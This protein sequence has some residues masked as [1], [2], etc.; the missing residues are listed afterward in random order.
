MRTLKAIILGIIF[1]SGMMPFAFADVYINVMAVNGAQERKETSVKY[2]LPGDLKE[3]DILDTSGLTLQYNV[4]DANYYVTGSVTLDPKETKTF[5]IRVKD[6]WRITPEQTKQIKD[7][8]DRGFEQVGKLYDAAKGEELK[9]RLEKKLDEITQQQAAANSV[10]QRI[11]AYRSY[12][13]EVARIRDEALAVDYWKSSP[14]QVKADRIIRLKID[15]ENPIDGE[16]KPIKEKQYL[17]T[18]VKP[19]DVV[20]P[21][22]FEIRYDQQRQQAFLFKEEE[23]PQGQKRSYSIGIRDIWHIEQGDMDY[24]RKRAD[25]ANDFLKNSK[26]A[27][28]AKILYDQIDPALKSI[29]TAQKKTMEITEHISTYR[30]NLKSFNEAKSDVEN[31]EKLLALYREELEKTKVENVLKKVRSLKGLADLSQQVFAKKP[32]ETATWGFIGWILL[33][34]GVLSVVYFIVLLIRSN[35]AKIKPVVEAEEKPKEQP[36]K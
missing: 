23:I 31:I 24:L 28:T 3:E 32:T 4:A 19:Q 10:E 14:E 20:E 34:V 9:Q 18:E 13:N 1:L 17:P 30:D 33:A 2:N 25:Y 6:I 15:T 26:Y 35:A 29:E 8:I 7:E 27:Q 12:R 5:R 22:G 36:K 11:D 16:T 21:E